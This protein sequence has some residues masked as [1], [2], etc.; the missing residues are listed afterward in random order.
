[1]N[2]QHL[3]SLPEDDMTA[4]VGGR[5]VASGLLARADSPFVAAALTIVQNSL[6]LVAGEPG[7]KGGRQGKPGCTGGSKAWKEMKK[8][9]GRHCW[10]L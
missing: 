5:W 9:G 2:G 10:L 1:M 8:G 7:C 3:R 6:E 4:M